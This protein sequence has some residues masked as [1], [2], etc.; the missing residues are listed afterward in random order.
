MVMKKNI[1]L[2][3]TAFLLL[4][5][6]FL[7]QASASVPKYASI[8]VTLGLGDSAL[9]GPYNITFS[10]VSLTWD[11]VYISVS[12]PQGTSSS[13]LRQ[14][15]SLYYPVN[16]ENALLVVTV[17]WIQKD[18]QAVL[19]NVQSP[20][21]K[22]YSN[23][24]ISKGS[25]ITLPEGY[26]PIK[27]TLE[28]SS[29]TDTAF[30][31]TMPYGETYTVTIPEGGA[32]GVSYK[33]GAGHSYLNYLF[34]EVLDAT[35]SG[36]RVNIYAPRVASV[37]FRIVKKKTGEQTG[38]FKVSTTLIYGDLLYTGEKL[39]ITYNGTKYY[40]ELV[41]VIPDVV[42]V[43]AYKGNETIGT[44]TLSVGDIPKAVSGTPFMLAVQKTEPDYKRAIIRIYGPI[45]AEVT[46]ILRSA[47]VV[48]NITAVPKKVLL[49]QDIV[50]SI[51]VEN[52]GRGNAYQLN[53][54]APIPNGFQ[55]ISMTK[56]WQVKN[57]PA[58]T[59]LPMLVYVLRPTKVGKFDIGKVIV[60]YY[61][62]QS[63]ETGKMKTIYS[64]PLTGIVV[65]N[66]PALSVSGSAY[67]GTWS[68]YVR[69]KVNTTVKV[70]L[71]VIAS[72][73]NPDY[74]FVK[75]AT[76]YL[77][78]P[79]GLQGPSEVK[80]GD[81]KAG[82]S[83]SV[84]VDLKVTKEALLNVGATLIYQDPLGEEHQLQTGNLV[85]INSIP[86]E[87]VVKEVKV[88]PKPE[89]LPAYIN[90]TLSAMDDPTPVAEE[91]VG[92]ASHYVPPKGN[93]WK[94]TALVFIIA[95][96]VLGALTYNYYSQLE[97]LREKVL[98]KK[99]RRPGG[100]PK[101][102]EEEEIIES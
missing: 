70:K 78:L 46:P 65:Y 101:K 93:P 5:S 75:N 63:L 68:D 30:K 54:A 92:V 100:L 24:T 42:K 72:E 89:E 51:G 91:I 7:Q 83:K 88:W 76:L 35:N 40:F 27:I 94:P 50:L 52:F 79:K 64:K 26:P 57:L 48:A 60:T 80:L 53:V 69:V 2:I 85:S 29:S 10:D 15:D 12:G 96:I 86:R 98:R 66:V 36:A 22:V 77:T 39:P 16:N 67:N 45:E 34:I 19:L 13:V 4:Q 20:L 97:K 55:L 14:G 47:E 74:E 49:G 28:S 17:V 61:D 44:Y 62:D 82:D 9:L 23:K 31:V 41:S 8:S 71:T 32:K 73:G 11:Q 43:K 3:L 81:L 56:S 6:A 95:T 18:N 38:T 33:L 99:Q 59:R 102:E 37:S 90:K 21:I 25:S 87:V 1:A 84:I 58:F